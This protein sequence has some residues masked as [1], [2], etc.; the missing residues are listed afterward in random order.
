MAWRMSEGELPYRDF[1]LF[2]PPYFVMLTS[3]LFNIFGK[4]FIYYT[5]TGLLITRVLMWIMLYKMMANVFKPIYVF[6]WYN[7]GT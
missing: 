6:F 2:M 4:Q 3:F 1:Y 5:F 7:Y